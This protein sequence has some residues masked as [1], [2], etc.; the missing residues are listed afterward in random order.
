MGHLAELVKLNLLVYGDDV[1][2]AYANNTQHFFDKYRASDENVRNTRVGEIKPGLFYF[3]HYM[4]DSAW[5][6]YAPVFVVDFK[7]F[8]GMVVLNCVNMNFLPLQTRVSLFDPFIREKDFDNK[9]FIIKSNYDNVYRELKK[10]R[11]EWSLME[12]NAAQIVSAHRISMFSLPRFLYSGHPKAK[13]DPTK[14]LQIWKK[15]YAEQDK[16]D[17][18]MMS[19]SIDEFYDAQKEIGDKY[20][21]LKGHIKRLRKSNRKYGSR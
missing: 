18:E 5:M 15:K 14:L 13:Y 10:S 6:R 16:R 21:V 17:K 9:N 7:K 19:A 12:F 3:F 2:S 20:S 11:F 1:V 4:D 8:D